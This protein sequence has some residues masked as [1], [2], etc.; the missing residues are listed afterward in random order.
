M[1]V[2]VAPRKKSE[3]PYEDLIRRLHTDAIWD[4]LDLRKAK[5]IVGWKVAEKWPQK[6]VYN[7]QGEE[8]RRRDVVIRYCYS[9]PIHAQQL[10]DYFLDGLSSI[11]MAVVGTIVSR[12]KMVYELGQEF[13]DR[14]REILSKP[15]KLN[16][17][18]TSVAER[19]CT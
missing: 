7:D 6:V 13:D 12:D 2:Y 3:N 9:K 15:E 1:R 16:V 19:Y 10:L 11:P 4:L 8:V 5:A 14:N 18:Y 17:H